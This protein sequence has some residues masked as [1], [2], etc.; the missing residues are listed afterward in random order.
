M[1][2]QKAVSFVRNVYRYFLEEGDRDSW[3]LFIQIIS[4][5]KEVKDR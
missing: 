4:K 3:K 2:S 5:L 1:V